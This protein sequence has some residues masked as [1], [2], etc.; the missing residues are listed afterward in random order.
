MK[1]MKNWNY[2]SL[3]MLFMFVATAATAAMPARQ[4]FSRNIKKDF[5]VSSSGGVGIHN[6]YGKIDIKTWD[7]D[8]VSVDVTIIVRANN[9]KEAQETFNRIRVDF[10]EKPDYV[11]ARTYIESKGGNGWN[12]NWNGNNNCDYTINYQVYMPKVN[13]L[14]LSN[15]YGDSFVAYLD[16]WLNADVK[17]GNIKMEGTKESITASVGYGNAN[18]GTTQNLTCNVSYG[19][20]NLREATNTALD[21]KYSEMNVGKTTNL[22]IKSR[23]DT[24]EIGA[25]TNLTNEGK[26]D[27]FD[28]TSVENTTFDTKYTDIKIGRLLNAANMD[29]QYGN[30]DIVF[31]SKN[32]SGVDIKG[33]YTDCS[34]RV[35][36]GANYLLDASTNYADIKYP[37]AMNVSNRRNNDNSETVEGY[38]GGK[39]GK[40]VIK[41]RLS[42]G[43][44]KIK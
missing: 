16:R 39:G 40:G 42:Y 14:D 11:Q 17:Y 36:D 33:S 22:A 25:V 19:K 43:D 23:Y 31:L 3:L 38:V 7:K 28:I 30:L 44:L 34:V 26:Y 24:Y 21:T 2:N 12:W 10:S 13:Y 41:A 20:L 18:I 5:K 9:E 37:S 29:M 1:K 35:E 4:E 6:Q 8:E 27:H 15:K 32:F